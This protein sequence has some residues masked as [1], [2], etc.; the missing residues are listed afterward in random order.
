MAS[1]LVREWTGLQ[2][3]PVATQQTLYELMNK[4]KEENVSFLTILVLGKGG[5]GKSSTVNS[6]IG[7]RVA[8][9]SAFQSEA[10]RPILCSRTRAGFTLNIIDTPGL[11]EGGYVNDHALDLIKRFLINKTIDVL[12]YVDRLDSYRVDNLDRQVVK[13]ITNT[14]G[15]QIWQKSLLVLTHAQMSPPDGLSYAEFVKKRSA[16]LHAAVFE[17]AGFRKIE[18]VKDLEMKAKNTVASSVSTFS[19]TMK[20]T[21]SRIERERRIPAQLHWILRGTVWMIKSAYDMVRG[22]ASKVPAHLKTLPLPL[23][24]KI[25][26][27]LVENSGRCNTN[28]GGEKILPDDTV[29]IPNL[30]KNIVEV[31][32]NGSKPVLIDKKLIEGTDPNQMGKLLIPLV[33]FLQYRFLLEPMRRK[34]LRLSDWEDGFEQSSSSR[35]LFP[36]IEEL[37]ARVPIRAKDLEEEE[38]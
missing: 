4:L 13:A 21:V 38:E 5:V 19:R 9:V 35:L 18:I 12:L 3:F 23:C 36:E 16:A 14:F 10:M 37:E 29:W 20:Y 2:Q 7:E 11:V 6:L 31:A 1:Q 27:V 25:P 17:G 8:V 32:T 33:L 30:V 28:D 26:V 22:T 24:K 34:A 15:Q